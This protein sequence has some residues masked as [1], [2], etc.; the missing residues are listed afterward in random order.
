MPHIFLR[1]AAAVTIKIFVCI[2]CFDWSFSSFLFC[3]LLLC[4]KEKGSLLLSRV[5]FC[6]SVFFLNNGTR[7]RAILFFIPGACD[8]RA[9]RFCV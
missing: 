8:G 1:T 3:S 6:V 2:F 7:R 9:K 5:A 4:N